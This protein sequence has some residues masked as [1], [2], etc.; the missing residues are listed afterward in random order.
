MAAPSCPHCG[1]KF[2]RNYGVQRH[3]ENRVCEGSRALGKAKPYR[4]D[5]CERSFGS[6]SA[7][8][9][10]AKA[11]G[12]AEA[13][14]AA[15][16][17]PPPP[18]VHITVVQIVPWRPPDFGIEV[19]AEMV[20]DSL[21]ESA[22]PTVRS[23]YPDILRRCHGDL[24]RRNVQV[25]DEGEELA[26]VLASAWEARALDA[27]LRPVFDT[28]HRQLGKVFS[29]EWV[30]RTSQH[31]N[32]AKERVLTDEHLEE[33]VNLRSAYD[34]LTDDVADHL[35]GDFEAQLRSNRMALESALG[36]RRAVLALKAT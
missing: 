25:C 8:S 14:A 22:R 1:R 12:A 26:L 9:R 10:H 28:I 34:L 16:S 7:R 27:A 15:A 21:N 18:S 11:C 30:A 6:A 2:A 23:F 29:R 24:A 36:S 4:C 35:R 20:R 19:T 3:I 5:T 32:A 31:K 17:E 13:A 33:L